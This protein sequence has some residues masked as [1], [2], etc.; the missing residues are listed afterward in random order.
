MTKEILYVP[1]DNTYVFECPH[2]ECYV[3]VLR[4]EINCQ[5]FRHGIIKDTKQGIPPHAP[6]ELC[7]YLL[8]N[9]LIDGCGK[10]F[11]LSFKDN[12]GYVEVC[13]YI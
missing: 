12:V 2:C 3:Q 6:K 10:P 1:D 7:D 13:D 11:R 5:I 8:A 4:N 9:S